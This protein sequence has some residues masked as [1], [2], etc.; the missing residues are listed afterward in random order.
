MTRPDTTAWRSTLDTS[1]VWLWTALLALELTVVVAYFALSPATVDRVR[2]V[3]YPFVWID[4]GLW[5]VWHTRPAVSSRRHRLVG[6][7]VATGYFLLVMSV[8][9]KVGLGVPGTQFDLRVAWY[10]PGW[11]PLVALDTAWIRLY[12]VPFEV[13]GYAALAYVVYANVLSVARGTLSGVLGLATCVGCTVPVLAPL[14]GLLGGP[15][16]GLTTTAYRFSYDLGTVVFLVT[17]WFLS[18]GHRRGRTS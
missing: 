17:L 16:T 14:V 12:L 18:A 7:V 13:I 9:G 2:Y 6:L 15:A 11:G 4:A 3:V 1:T 10:V 5:A 8:A